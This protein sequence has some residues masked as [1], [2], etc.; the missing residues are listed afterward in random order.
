MFLHERKKG[1]DDT[2][3]LSKTWNEMKEAN[4]EEYKRFVEMAEEKMKKVWNHQMVLKHNLNHKRKTSIELIRQMLKVLK[5]RISLF[6]V[7]KS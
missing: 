2:T 4:N 7:E 5:M 6:L 1:M 3:E